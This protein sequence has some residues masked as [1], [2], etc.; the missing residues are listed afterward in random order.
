LRKILL[1]DAD[2]KI[3]NLSLMKLSQYYK[4]QGC[5]IDLLKLNL[6]YYPNKKKYHRSI[7]NLGYEKIFC[8]VIFEGN[9]PFIHGDNIVFGGTGVDL[10]TELPS[11]VNQ[12]EPD[13]SIYPENDTSY[14]FLTRGCIRKCKFCKV[15]E[16]EGYIRQVHSP[17]EIIRH[18][19]VKFMDNNILALPTHNE[20]LQEL[21][22]LKVRCEFNQGLDIRLLTE[23][24]SKL[25]SQ[26]NYSGNYTFAFDDI[27]YENVI[28]N[29]LPLLSWRKRDQ[30][31]F[32]CYVHPDMPIE[33]TLYRLKWMRNH[34]CIPYVMRDIACWSDDRHHFYTD[35]AA[36]ANQI[37]IWKTMPF[38]T[39]VYKRHLT[40]KRQT[41]NKQVADVYNSAAQH[42]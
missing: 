18:K 28:N 38:E 35:L 26:L 15:P 8:S 9:L 39:Y 27:K 1:I 3:P 29:Q 32:F 24:N 16:K 11:E 40:K 30:I 13:Y 7:S 41:I 23:E 20:I 42:L 34:E 19:K 12:C 37:R 21:V 33:D 22:M 25:L 10:V 31:R 2:S 14:G 4:Q 5:V 6:P 17:S 36:W